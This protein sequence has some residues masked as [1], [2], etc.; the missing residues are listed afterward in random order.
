[1]L[2]EEPSARRWI[3]VERRQLRFGYS[4]AAYAP[5]LASIA[6]VCVFDARRV[7]RAFQARPPGSPASPG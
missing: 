4:A 2:A 7:P 1:M 6:R 3:L 5:V